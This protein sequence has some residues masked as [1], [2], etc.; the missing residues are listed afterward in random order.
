MGSCCLLLVSLSFIYSLFFT[1]IQYSMSN[2]SCIVYPISCNKLYVSCIEYPIIQYCV[3]GDL[4]ILYPDLTRISCILWP[5]LT[6][7][8]L[9]RTLISILYHVSCILYPE[10]CIVWP[11]SKN[12]LYLGMGSVSPLSRRCLF[13]RRRK[14]GSRKVI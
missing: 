7:Y 13:I 12:I 5:N 1:C 3:T 4:C 10:S 9:P 11:R 6:F 8:S 2:I 14:L